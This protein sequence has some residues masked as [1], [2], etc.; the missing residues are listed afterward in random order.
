MALISITIYDISSPS[1]LLNKILVQWH[2]LFMDGRVFLKSLYVWLTKGNLSNTLNC[3]QCILWLKKKQQLY[4]LM[5][6]YSPYLMTYHL[7]FR[8]QK[9][10]KMKTSFCTMLC[11]IEG[12]KYG[13]MLQVVH[14]LLTL[15]LESDS[16]HSI[17]R[18]CTP[19]VNHRRRKCIF[20]IRQPHF[21]AQIC[22]I[23]ILFS[24]LFTTEEGVRHFTGLQKFTV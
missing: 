8:N 14:F 20:K 17:E 15:C 12:R 21:R 23:Q 24:C 5:H 19:F 6:G 11:N 13:F 22:K 10:K 16:R 7:V 18:L 9:R 1:Y 2:V 4:M 3:N